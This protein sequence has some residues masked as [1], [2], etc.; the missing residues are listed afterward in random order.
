MISFKVKMK[1]LQICEQLTHELLEYEW[2]I[3][4]TKRHYLELEGAKPI[5]EICLLCSTVNEFDLPVFTEKVQ[6]T[7]KATT[8]RITKDFLRSSNGPLVRLHPPVEG[9][10]INKN[11]GLPSFLV[12]MVTGKPYAK[13]AGLMIPNS[14]FC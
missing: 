10:V 6:V 12:A 11:R 9:T 2:C 5:D 13:D 14:S 1:K 4:E 3:H 8:S 7:T